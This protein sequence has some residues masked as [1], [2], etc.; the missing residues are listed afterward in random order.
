MKI[1]FIGN[2][3]TVIDDEGIES[4]I[5][6]RIINERC[7]FSIRDIAL[8]LNTSSSTVT[9]V[10]SRIFREEE[11]S[12][13]EVM[14]SIV[15]LDCDGRNKSSHFYSIEMFFAIAFR[16]RTSRANQVRRWASLYISKQL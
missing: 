11:F 2:E 5:V 1:D 14:Q 6:G 8:L 10:I 3:L 12:K 15:L 7:M 16:L 9:N 4:S 13:E